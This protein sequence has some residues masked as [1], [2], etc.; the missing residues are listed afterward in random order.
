MNSFSTSRDTLEFLKHYPDL[1]EGLEFMQSQAPKV[2]ARTLAPASWPENPQLEW[3]P[4]GHGDLYPSLLGSGS[5][6][7]LLAG[8]LKYAFVSNSDNLGAT[9]EPALLTYFAESKKSFLMEVAERTPSDRKGGHLAERNGR[10]LLREFA[11]CPE[12]DGKSFQD[13]SKHRFF[14]TN[15]L[16]LR[17]DHL[18]ELLARHGGF[19][20]LPLIKNRKTVDPRNKNSPEVFQL[21]S[22]MGAAIE[23]FENSAAIVVPRSRFA[24]VKTTSDLLGLRSDAY[25]LTEDWRLV[26]DGAQGS[27]PPTIEL[28]PNHYRLVDQ[29]DRATANGVP[30]LKQ[31]VKLAVAGPVQFNSK[32]I[33]R[34]NV[35]IRNNASTFHSLPPGE[36]ADSDLV[37]S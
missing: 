37:L 20:P 13:I 14:N 28:D 12:E 27:Q 29:L 36:Y 30:S 2:D 34:G 17:L 1:G 15:S 16:W 26:V 3:C 8:N 21:E 11:Q 9:L 33:F 31:C 6:D 5:L 7:R 35:S 18:K 32:N 19:I 4:P 25:R 23:T 10:L 24:P 22:A